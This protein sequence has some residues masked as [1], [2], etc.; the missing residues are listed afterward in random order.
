MYV[1]LPVEALG[2]NCH[3]LEISDRLE[4]VNVITNISSRHSHSHVIVFY[5]SAHAVIPNLQ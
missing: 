4:R 3:G 2:V 1:D 5:L